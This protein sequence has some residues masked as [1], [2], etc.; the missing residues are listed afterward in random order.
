MQK[1][2]F[3]IAC[4]VHYRS[5]MHMPAVSVHFALILE[6]YCRGCIPHIEVL[7]KQVRYFHFFSFNFVIFFFKFNLEI[8]FI[9]F[10]IKSE[11]THMIIDVARRWSSK[12]HESKKSLHPNNKFRYKVE[13]AIMDIGFHSD[14]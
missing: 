2:E 7:K 10:Y 5:E 13:L 11:Y 14:K 8:E 1:L 12:Q 4:V 3:M 9:V 6:A